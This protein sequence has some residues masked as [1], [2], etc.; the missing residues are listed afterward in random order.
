MVTLTSRMAYNEV[1]STGKD[2]TQAADILSHVL[3]GYDYSRQELKR[4][5]GLEINAICG[6]VNELL[7][8]GKLEEGEMRKCNVTGRSIRPVRRVSH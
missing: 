6:R 8:A 5:T 7:K 2:T 1:Q 3:P 4:L